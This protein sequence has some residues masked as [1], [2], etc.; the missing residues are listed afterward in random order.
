M[1][2]AVFWDVVP[3][4]LVDADRLI[5]EA[6][7]PPSSRLRMMMDAVCSSE[8]SVNIYYPIRRNIPADS[9]LHNRQ[10]FTTIFL[11]GIFLPSNHNVYNVGIFRQWGVLVTS[12]DSTEYTK[13]HTK[14]RR[15]TSLKHNYR[16]TCL[17]LV[18]QLTDY[19]YTRQCIMFLFAI[20]SCLHHPLLTSPVPQ[21]LASNRQNARHLSPSTQ[22]TAA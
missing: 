3:F 21:Q 18:M 8:T 4:C 10:H 22:H 20:H 16:K 13:I 12:Q 7:G 19:T 15:I 2:T 1:K 11:T 5:T 6:N 14:L 17:S 9:R